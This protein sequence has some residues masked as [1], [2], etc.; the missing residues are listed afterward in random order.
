MAPLA[1]AGDTR[2][3]GAARRSADWPERAID[4]LLDQRPH[5]PPRGATWSCRL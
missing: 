5:R 3:S 1:W 2:C 4:A